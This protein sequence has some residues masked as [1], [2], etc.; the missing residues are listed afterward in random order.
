MVQNGNFENSIKALEKIANGNY[1]VYSELARIQIAD[2][3][4]E[5]N[6]TQDALNMLQVIADNDELSPKVR[7]LAA[8]KLASYKI[9]T[10][11]SAEIVA[12][13]QP[14][15]DANNSWS[16]MA[17]EMVAMVSIKEGD[18]AKARNIYNDLLQ[19]NKIS[20][21]FRNRIQDMLSAL[22]DM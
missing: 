9:D 10:A 6:K 16:P 8:L 5:Q 20:D 11:S 14:I 22:S 21:N 18:F 1:G 7:N 2:V 12:L 17:Q 15:I 13:L 4:F 3:L 19:S